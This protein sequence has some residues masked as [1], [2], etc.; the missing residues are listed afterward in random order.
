MGP[1]GGKG[2]GGGF[3]RHSTG[4]PRHMRVGCVRLI[5]CNKKRKK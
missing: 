2:G 1:K 5:K 3:E 4:G